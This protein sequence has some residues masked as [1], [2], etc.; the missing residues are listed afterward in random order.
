MLLRKVIVALALLLPLGVGAGNIVPEPK[1]IEK[2][3]E[4]FTILTTTKITHSEKLRP[5]ADYLTKFLP[6][7]TQSANEAA[8]G[9]I[10]LGEDK[11]LAAE[12]YRLTI[13]KEGVRIVGGSYA[14][15]HCG[16]ETFLQ[17]LPSEVYGG[18]IKLPIVVGGCLV[19]DSPRFSYRGFMLDVCR[20]WIE[21]EELKAFIEN[22]AHHKIN[23]LHLHLS[24][25]E[26]WRI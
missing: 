16:V 9:V 6:L 2:R 7:T 22:L 1:R 23:K 24:D 8:G 13:G 5:L 18:E 25:D 4:A 17:L 12:E 21:V 10:A 3:G 26:G 20:T 11:N 14:G 15:V 19:E